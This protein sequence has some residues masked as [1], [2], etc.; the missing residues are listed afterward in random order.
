M[1]SVTELPGGLRRRAD[2]LPELAR[3]TVQ[4]AVD[5]PAQVGLVVAGSIVATRAALNIVRPRTPLEALALFV[6]LQV[7]VPVLATKAIEHGWLSL[8]VRDEAG[9]LVPL[10]PDA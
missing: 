8:R 2:R 1:E 6:V 3:A 7:G 10:R 5:N 9:R 4:L